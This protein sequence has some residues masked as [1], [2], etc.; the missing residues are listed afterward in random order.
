[1]PRIGLIRR[2]PD[3]ARSIDV[4]VPPESLPVLRADAKER[5]RT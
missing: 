2:K 1:M 4:L 3:V 5:Q